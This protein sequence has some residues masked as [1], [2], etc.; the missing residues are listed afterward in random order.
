MYL[1]D[2]RVIRL[3]LKDPFLVYAM[4]CHKNAEQQMFLL[5][6]CLRE[7]G[8]SPGVGANSMLSLQDL[9]RKAGTKPRYA[10]LY[11]ILIKWQY[12]I[13]AIRRAQAK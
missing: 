3:D 4:F 10:P 12:F 9:L 13:E 1:H 5:F 2:V 7:G 8:A 11:N 6:H